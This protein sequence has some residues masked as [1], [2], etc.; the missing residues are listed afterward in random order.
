MAAT[1]V[2]ASSAPKLTFFDSGITTQDQQDAKQMSDNLAA[3]V[4]CYT[5]DCSHQCKS[6][7]NQVAQMNGQP[8]QLSTNNRCNPG[9][10]RNLW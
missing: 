2:D 1:L 3:G 7:T 6:G 10:Y 5:T 4:T 9:E 8:N